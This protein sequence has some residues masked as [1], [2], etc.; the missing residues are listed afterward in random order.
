[1]KRS[2]FFIGLIFTV[3]LA[4]FFAGL[5]YERQILVAQLQLQRFHFSQ[6]RYKQWERFARHIKDDEKRFGSSRLQFPSMAAERT[7]R[8]AA[9][10]EKFERTRSGSKWADYR[11]IATFENIRKSNEAFSPRNVLLLDRNEISYPCYASVPSLEALTF[12]PGE[13]RRYELHF[14]IPVGSEPA[15]FFLVNSSGLS[16]FSLAAHEGPYYDPDLPNN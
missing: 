6:E 9:E 8:F 2:N 15:A 1:M 16:E 3:F 13:S 4:G 14:Y 12:K 11:L 7:H 10:I 5:I